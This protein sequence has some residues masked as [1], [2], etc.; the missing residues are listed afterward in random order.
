[1]ICWSHVSTAMLQYTVC[2]HTVC[3]GHFDSLYFRY[4]RRLLDDAAGD[5]GSC[6]VTLCC[7]NGPY[8]AALPRSSGG[9]CGADLSHDSG[10]CSGGWSSGAA[11]PCGV[12]LPLSQVGQCHGCMDLSPVLVLSSLLASVLPLVT[13]WEA[14]NIHDRLQ[15]NVSLNSIVALTQIKLDEVSWICDPRGA[16]RDFGPVKI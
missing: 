8:W 5:G 10:P 2:L 12:A 7:N 13:W 9:S 3:Q 1:M 15:C 14:D 6:G 16:A 11:P 4:V